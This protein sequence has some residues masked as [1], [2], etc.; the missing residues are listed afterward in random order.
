MTGK[1]GRGIEWGGA[2]G[3]PAAFVPASAYR[4]APK[5]EGEDQQQRQSKDRKGGGQGP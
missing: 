3:H 5:A 1:Y 2:G 4:V